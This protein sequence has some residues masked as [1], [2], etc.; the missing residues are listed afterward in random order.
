MFW[1]LRNMYM[2]IILV[3]IVCFVIRFTSGPKIE[4]KH[5]IDTKI[6]DFLSNGSFA[7]NFP[8]AVRPSG[9]PNNSVTLFLANS[10]SIFDR[11]LGG[12]EIIP[13]F[14]SSS[15]GLTAKWYISEQV[16]KGLNG[17]FDWN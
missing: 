11:Q 12:D 5:I 16:T 4:N 15:W 2:S 6:V 7:D 3:N 17:N 9:R 14:K 10:N 8:K 13:I 1:P